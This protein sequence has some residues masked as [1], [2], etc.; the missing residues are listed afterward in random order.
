HWL[1]GYL[2]TAVLVVVVTATAVQFDNLLEPHFFAGVTMMVIVFLIAILWGAGPAVFATIF[3]TVALDYAI[4][5]PIT[6][7]TFWSD[8]PD[9]LPFI[10]ASLVISL[11]TAQRERARRRARTAERLANER[12]DALEAADKLKDQFLS[13]ASHELK[14]PIAAIKGYAQLAERRLGQITEVSP[15]LTGTQEVLGKINQQTDRISSLV[16][17]LL[18]VS[19]IQAGKLDFRMEPCDLAVLCRQAIEEQQLASGRPISFVA[20]GE[21]VPITADSERIGQVLNNLLTN[22]LKYSD[23]NRPVRVLLSH[24]EKRALIQVQDEGVGIPGDELF[25]IFDRFF[26]A[27]TA[28]NGPQRGL[29]LGLA[30]CKEIVERHN[31]HIWATSEEGKGST[32][33]IELLAEGPPLMEQHV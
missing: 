10:V 8:L 9:F 32:F 25:L 22:A 29:G 17:D 33:T 20:S 28:R 3:S 30:I 2:L 19:R 12:A 27:R 11:L 6:K 23:E 1:A 26:R 13:L 18:D 7:L 14:T 24:Q 16:N 4:V 31:G 21:P 15:A 5:E